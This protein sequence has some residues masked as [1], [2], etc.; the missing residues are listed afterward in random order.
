MQVRQLVQALLYQL[1]YTPSQNR[2]YVEVYLIV[3]S[4][5]QPALGMFFPL[6]NNYFVEG[7]KLLERFGSV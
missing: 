3:L 5:E 6:M 7:G 1:D 4:L 2:W